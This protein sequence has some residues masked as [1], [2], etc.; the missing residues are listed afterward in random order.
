[1]RP[2]ILMNVRMAGQKVSSLHWLVSICHS[3]S[4]KLNISWT[5]SFLFDKQIFLQFLH[6]QQARLQRGTEHQRGSSREPE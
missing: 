5:L 6:Q 1:M 3:Q 2:I 4:L